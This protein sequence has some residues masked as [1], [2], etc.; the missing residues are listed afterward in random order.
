VRS[1]LALGVAVAVVALVVSEAAMRPSPEERFTLYGTFAAGAV[2]AA[3]VGWWLTRVHRRLSSLR[4]TVLAV[5]VTAVAVASGVV[6]LAAG[7]M[8]LAPADVR[9]V[10]A[11]LTLGT[12]LGLLVAIGVTGPLTGDLRQLAGAARRVADGDLTVRTGIER[13]DE[14]GEL[15]RSIDRMVDQLAEFE[16]QRQRDEAARHRLLAAVGHDLRTPLATLQAAVEALQDG[17]AADPER[18]L[19]AMAADV[20]LLRGMVDDLLVLTGLEAGEV[21]LERLPLDLTELADGAAEALAPVAA[22]AQVEIRL[23]ADGAVPVVGDARALDRVLR[24]LLDNALRH[25]P[26]GSTVRVAVQVDG[27]AGEVR[28]HDDGAGFPA[29]F[30][31][32]AFDRFSRADEARE[33]HGGG[34]GLGLAIA[35]ELVEAHGGRIWIE[36]GPGATVAFRLPASPASASPDTR[37]SRAPRA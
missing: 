36:P 1:A 13:A 27:G 12:G 9:V 14:V 24:N 25:A 23:D 8:L 7:A 4:W 18:Y 31:D 3:L 33:R 16:R 37:V 29:G 2:V 30:V 10:L 6:L 21:R 17:V 11:A 32:R 5:A 35:R 22:R 19:K 34:A 26:G 28:I 20:E 15:A